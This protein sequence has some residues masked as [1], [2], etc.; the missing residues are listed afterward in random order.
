MSVTANPITEGVLLSHAPNVFTAAETA[1]STEDNY[2]L[3]CLVEIDSEKIIRMS[4]ILNPNGSA[5]FEL[6]EVLRQTS[7]IHTALHPTALSDDSASIHYIPSAGDYPRR[8]QS[9]SRKNVVAEVEI[10]IGETYTDSNGNDQDN[11]FDTY[12]AVIIHGALQHPKLEW[13]AEDYKVVGAGSDSR[14]ALPL[15]IR[16][17]YNVT[18][19]DSDNGALGYFMNDGTVEASFFKLRLR[20][21]D[22]GDNLLDT[23]E[24]DIPSDFIVANTSY[25]V[26]FF[27]IYPDNLERQSLPVSNGM[28]RPSAVPNW[29][30]YIF[31]LIDRDRDIPITEPMRFNR[32]CE[33]SYENVRL[34]FVN[35]LGGWDY[36]NFD[37]RARQRVEVDRNESEKLPGTWG[38]AN[39]SL[40]SHDRGLDV[41]N[42]ISRERLTVTTKATISEVDVISKLINSREVVWLKEFNAPVAVRVTDSNVQK[43]R[44]GDRDYNTVS[45]TFETAIKEISA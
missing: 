6:R 11:V 12:E 37:L 18:V 15:T 3:Y 2:R 10:T 16:D 24:R 43:K 5:H 26:Q 45:I 21:Y 31:D 13:N 42:S 27:S 7:P 8:C 17:N 1:N 20:Y 28:T 40:N 38:D 33:T 36:V 25:S 34:G 9:L 39:F 4:R 35:N 44:S 30:Y 32:E 23:S 22:S 29:S 19:K 41:D 14:L